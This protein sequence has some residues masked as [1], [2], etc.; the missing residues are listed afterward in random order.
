[1]FTSIF[2]EGYTIWLVADLPYWKIWKSVG[3]MKSRKKKTCSEPPIS[4]GISN[5]QT[6]QLNL[7]QQK[8]F[9]YWMV[10]S[11]MVLDNMIPNVVYA[12]NQ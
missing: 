2:L 3:M 9:I 8:D 5:F 12:S 1:M 11:P 10:K 4:Y 6:T 7:F